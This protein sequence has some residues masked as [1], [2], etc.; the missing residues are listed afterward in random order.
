MSEKSRASVVSARNRTNDEFNVILNL[1][2]FPPDI[3]RRKGF[4]TSDVTLS[5]DAFEINVLILYTSLR[6]SLMHQW[7]LYC[8]VSIKNFIAKCI[9]ISSGKS[10]TQHPTDKFL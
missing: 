5:E 7:Q 2:G 6:D 9:F 10:D 4:V 1:V 3:E 8:H